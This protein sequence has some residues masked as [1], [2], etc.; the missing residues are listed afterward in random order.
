[1]TW[2]TV[3]EHTVVDKL[4][5]KRSSSVLLVHEQQASEK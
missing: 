3:F 2:Q 4:C 1:M 5:S